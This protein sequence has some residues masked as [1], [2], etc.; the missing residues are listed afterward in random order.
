MPLT[1]F[2]GISVIKLYLVFFIYIFCTHFIKSTELIEY[3][4]SGRA[5]SKH[6]QLT[7]WSRFLHLK[8]IYSHVMKKLPSCYEGQSFITIC[9]PYPYMEEYLHSVTD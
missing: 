6:D 7:P 9:V 5:V 4:M 2:G 8:L 1:L 3:R